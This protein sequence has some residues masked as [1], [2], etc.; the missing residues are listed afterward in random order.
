M[1]T[2]KSFSNALSKYDVKT[3]VLNKNTNIRS[4]RNIGEIV[5]ELRNK[6]LEEVARYQTDT[7]VRDKT[8]PE[9][10]KTAQQVAENMKNASDY[11]GDSAFQSSYE[12]DS[13]TE[14]TG[15]VSE[16]GSYSQEDAG[17]SFAGDDP[18]FNTGGLASKKKKPKPKKMK[19][20]GLASKK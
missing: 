1:Y 3:T 4:K 17:G 20:G 15:T 14:D 10:I 18:S 19:R 11:F 8:D 12:A 16:S 2:N 5:T 6:K 9:S 7:G 13:G